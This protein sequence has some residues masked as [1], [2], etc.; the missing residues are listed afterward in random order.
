MRTMR[1]PDS[2]GNSGSWYCCP[3]VHGMRSPVGISP[4]ARLLLELFLLMAP[5][6]A[7][8]TTAITS[9][10][11]FCKEEMTNPEPS[12]GLKTSVV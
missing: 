12:V 8:W 6:S 10:S 1:A 11:V 3:M 5:S 2:I 7:I 9:G 4:R